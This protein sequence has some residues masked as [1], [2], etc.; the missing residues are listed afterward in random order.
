ME[1]RTRKPVVKLQAGEFTSGILAKEL[2]IN[3]TTVAAALTLV[4]GIIQSHREVGRIRIYL[5]S[6]LEKWYSNIGKEKAISSIREAGKLMNF[7]Y[8]WR[9]NA[10]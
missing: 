5:Y 8:S 3:R 6:D 9:N 10:R 4:P 7:H 2:G 1:K